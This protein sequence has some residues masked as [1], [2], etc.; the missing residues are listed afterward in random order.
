VADASRLLDGIRVLDVASFIAGPVSTTV[1]A[2]FG[3]DVVKIEPPGGDPYRVR[4]AGYPASP[5]NFPWIV[6]NRS[7]RGDWRPILEAS[8]IAFSAV[9]TL[10]DIPGDAQMTASGALVPLDDPRAGATLTVSSPIQIE[11]Q[12]KV[13]ATLPPALGEHT[14][15]VLREAGVTDDE[16]DGLLRT[17]VVVQ[18]GWSPPA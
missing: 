15:A 13:P 1:M 17:G 6:D 9:G 10:D 2:E 7:K 5:H 11:G 18:A 8:G 16:I 4:G 12:A 14:V 3:A